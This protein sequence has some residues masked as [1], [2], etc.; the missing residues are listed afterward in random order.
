VV[1]VAMGGSRATGLNDEAS[2]IDIYV[3]ATTPVPLSLRDRIARTLGEEIELDNRFWEPGD[4]WQARQGGASIDIMYRT[5]GWIEEQLDRV[6][7]GFEASVGYSTCLW[8]NVQTS[9]PLFD[10]DGWFAR[11]QGKAR[12][13][14]PEVLRRAV[15][16]KNY[17]ILAKTRS[18]YVHQ[19]KEAV[20]R[21]DDPAV[22]HRTA[23]YLASYFDTLFAF[24]RVP[25]PGEKRLVGSL[26]RLC[27][28]IPTGAEEEIRGLAAAMSDPGRQTLASRLGDLAGGLASLLRTDER[29]SDL[30]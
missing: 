13:D 3:Y 8:C 7:V 28:Q 14:Y 5:P 4:E 1:A 27:P 12:I 21:N 29:L 19:V 18:S 17:P 10:R 24:N 20:R 11:L 9:E 22:L 16:A 25:H 23:A 30:A 2:D 26:R 6:L 15:V